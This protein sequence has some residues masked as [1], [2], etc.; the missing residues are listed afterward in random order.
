MNKSGVFAHAANF[1]PGF[2]GLRRR[3]WIGVGVGLLV[4]IALLIWAALALIGWL[5]GQTQSLAGTAPETL[6]ETARSVLEQVKGFV[7]GA[8]GML[9]QVKERVPSVQ[10]TL[11]QVKEGIPS[12]REKLAEFVPA[13]TP[14]TPLQRDVSGEDLGPVERP[15]GLIRTLWQRADGQAVVAYEGKANYV[16]VLDHYEKGFATRGFKHYVESATQNA[17]THK[18]SNGSEQYVVKIAQKT[19][20]LVSVRLETTQPQ[21]LLDTGRCN[22][23]AHCP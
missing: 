7:P 21:E 18:Y 8:Q 1:A 2:L 3:T 16:T 10:S 14:E 23:Q 19:K 9:D 11:D 5:W 15:A 22:S 12:A 4:L 6:Q 13:L 17:E 20:S